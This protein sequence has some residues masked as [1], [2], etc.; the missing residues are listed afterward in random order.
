MAATFDLFK[1]QPDGNAYW[2]ETAPDLE[3]AKA[4]ARLLIE[5]FGGQFVIMDSATGEKT[6]VPGNQ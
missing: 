5:H 4:Q 6:F 2:V 3:T 1:I